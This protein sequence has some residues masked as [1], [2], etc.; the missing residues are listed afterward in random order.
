MLRRTPLALEVET[1]RLL[2]EAA[3]RREQ[4]VSSLVREIIEQWLKKDDPIWKVV[5]IASGGA[6]YVSENI[7]KHL[8]QDDWKEG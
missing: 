8:Y 6:P 3:Q 7:D 1:Y 2:K 5:G 4:S